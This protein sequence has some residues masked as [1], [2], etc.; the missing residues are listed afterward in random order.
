M[1]ADVLPVDCL[2]VGIRH[3]IWTVRAAITTMTG[4]IML[5]KEM[6]S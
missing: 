1:L 5:P 2:S 6:F 4:E 3:K